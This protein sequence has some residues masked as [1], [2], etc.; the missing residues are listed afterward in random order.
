MKFFKGAA[1]TILV[2]AILGGLVEFG[3]RA[4]IPSTIE[5][6]SRIAL[7]VPQG[8]EVT[9]SVPGSMAL[10]ALRWRVANVTIEAEDV[11]LSEGVEADARLEVGSVPLIPTFGRLRDGTATFTVPTDQIDAI[12]RLVSGGIAQ[13]GEMRDGELVA[14][15]TLTEE[16]FDLPYSGSFE[17]DYEGA[18]ELAV[19]NG[20]IIVTP[21]SID[22][23]GS[24]PVSDFL[25]ETMMEPRTVC[26]ANML[27]KGI[28]LTGI[29][30]LPSGEVVLEAR[31]SE[32]LLSRVD[33]RFPGVC[34]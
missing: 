17:M 16:Q 3:L 30:A 8:S 21:T 6:G 4:F 25:R 33:E 24:G 12:T 19:E 29:E 1:I 32:R 15:G 13:W 22:V 9:A 34:S 23:D 26:I 27:P 14:G 20:D 31:L 10:N 11:P 2:L 7:R 28:T 5:G 18:I